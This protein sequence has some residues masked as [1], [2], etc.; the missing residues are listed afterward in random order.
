MSDVLVDAGPLTAFLDRSEYRDRNP[1]LADLSLLAAS[2]RTGVRTIP[3]FDRDF[4]IYRR[5]DRRALRC[6]LL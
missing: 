4:S 6:P 2:E 3:T 5:R 1:D